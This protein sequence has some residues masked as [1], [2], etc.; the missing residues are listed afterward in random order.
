M[1]ISHYDSNYF[2]YLSRFF[3][4]SKASTNRLTRSSFLLAQSPSTLPLSS[5][6]AGNVIR[7]HQWLINQFFHGNV[8]SSALSR[9]TTQVAKK[10]LFA[11]SLKA[12]LLLWRPPL[13][14][15]SFFS[16]A[17]AA[18]CDE[19]RLTSRTQ[20]GIKLPRT[21]FSFP[22]HQTNKVFFPI[23]QQ[24]SEL[25]FHRNISIA[26]HQRTFKQVEWSRSRDVNNCELDE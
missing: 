22:S 3:N 17:A 15:R 6:I 5:R 26:H 8:T 16:S 24:S 23:I 12:F 14:F 10:N 13:I 21:T 4:C 2:Y 9:L 7:H 1:E 20:S 19:N 18:A 11:L 25:K